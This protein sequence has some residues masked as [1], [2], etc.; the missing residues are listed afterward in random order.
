VPA[1]GTR[2][3]DVSIGELRVQD[4]A[5]T[6]VDATVTPAARLGV[7][8]IGLSVKNAG[9][10]AR[11]P[12]QIELEATLPGGGPLTV[13]G[14]GELAQPGVRVGKPWALV[15]RDERG[16]LSLVAA[17]TARPRVTAAPEPPPAA[18]R[19]LRPEVAVRHA[20]FEDGGTNIVDDSVEPAARFQ[21]RGTR[22]EMRNFT[23]PVKMP[24]EVALATPMPRG[25]RLEG[26]GTFQVDPSRMDVRVRLMGVA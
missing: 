4:G 18:R 14:N 1:G 16:Q 15:D 12:A 26:R 6:L 13:A 11:G 17:L 7:S 10:P 9:W 21:V 2:A 23:W 25:G 5:L 19:R 22:L 3:A 8:A 20:L 24:A